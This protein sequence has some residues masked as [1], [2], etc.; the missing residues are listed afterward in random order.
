MDFSNITNSINA[1]I[2]TST[3]EYDNDEEIYQKPTNYLPIDWSLKTRIR[4]LS[5]TP[6]PGNCLKTNQEASGITR[7]Y[8][9]FVIIF[10]YF[11]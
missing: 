2:A 11:L 5:K 4:I 7:F 6:L 1:S 9:Y 3:K 8:L 10:I